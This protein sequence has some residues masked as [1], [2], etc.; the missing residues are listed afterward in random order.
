M[1]TDQV[2]LKIVPENKLQAVVDIPGTDIGFIKVGMPA[3]VSVD[4]FPSKEFGYIQGTLSRV[5]SDA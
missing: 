3:S 1:G 5:G 4:S 2:L